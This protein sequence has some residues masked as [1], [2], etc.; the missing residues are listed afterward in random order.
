MTVATVGIALPEFVVAGL[1]IILFVFYLA[2]VS[3]R[4]LGI[5]AAAGAAG[6]LPRVA[7]RRLHRPADAQRH[8]RRALARLHSHGPRQ[9][10]DAATVIIR[11][12]LKGALLP[13]LVVSRPRDGRHSHRL[14]RRGKDL[15]HSRPRRASRAVGPQ[16]DYTLAMA[17]TMLYTV[18]L[19]AMNFIVDVFVQAARPA[20][21]ARRMSR[22]LADK[23][24]AARRSRRRRPTTAHATSVARRSAADARRF[25]RP[26][27][28]ATA[29]AQPGGDG[30]ACRF[31][32]LLG[33][34][35][36][37]TPLLPLQP[38]RTVH[39]ERAFGRAGVFAAVRSQRRPWIDDDGNRSTTP[40]FEHGFGDSNGFDRIDCCGSRAAIFGRWE[41]TSWC[42]CDRLGRD[43]LARLFWGAR[44]SL[45]VGLVA[46]LVS[47]VIGVSY[48]ATSGYLGG[49]VDAAMMR[50]VDVL[51]SIPFIFVVILL[52][53]VLDDPKVE[54]RGL[55]ELR[56]RESD[57][58]L[59]LRRRRDLL[60]DDGPRRPRAGACR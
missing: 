2:A 14:A 7:V 54:R 19:C 57:H 48:G 1:A 33:Y 10:L 39:T 26:R 3:R 40:T 58:D 27:C 23:P 45:V 59:L 29:E 25:A 50:I 32:S 46:A 24:N 41:A 30:R 5:A 56:H 36:V 21:Q 22:R 9:R 38:P 53:T 17:L 60:A 51:Y 43:L 44:V 8:A 11:H 42:G 13:V 15:R 37:F 55:R 34:R 16:R 49:R 52:I 35:R 12:A 4:R 18:L 47:L 6:R 28:V 31:W 20:D